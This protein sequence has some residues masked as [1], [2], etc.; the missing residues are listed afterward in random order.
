ME[1]QNGARVVFKGSISSGHPSDWPW[2][3]EFFADGGSSIDLTEAR[4][5]DEDYVNLVMN[6]GGTLVTAPGQTFDFTQAGAIGFDI[7]GADENTPGANL[8]V[9]IPGGAFAAVYQLNSSTYRTASVRV[10]SGLLL[11]DKSATI[12]TGD[13]TIAKSAVTNHGAVKADEIILNTEG[14]MANRGSLTGNVTATDASA[15]TNE[16]AISGLTTVQQGALIQ[17]GGSYDRTFVEQGG[18]LA[19]STTAAALRGTPL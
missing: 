2:Q 5:K 16:G 3:G 14:A 12:T 13:F 9:G 19:A 18:I 1:A 6:E 11:I 15:L 10:D 7:V 4:T 17:G 8:Q